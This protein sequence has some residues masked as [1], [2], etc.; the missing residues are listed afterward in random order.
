MDGIV[1]KPQFDTSKFVAGRPLKIRTSDRN[2]WYEFNHTCLVVSCKPLALEVAYII[3]K[4]GSAALQT[5]VIP[6][7]KVSD[8]TLKITFLEEDK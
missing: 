4:S 5:R 8:E 2:E 3:E 1:S 7:E 6:I